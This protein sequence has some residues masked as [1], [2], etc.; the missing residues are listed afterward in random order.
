MCVSHILADR[1]ELVI[2]TLQYVRQ[3]IRRVELVH[4]QTRPAAGNPLTELTP[5][6]ATTTISVSSLYRNHFSQNDPTDRTTTRTLLQARQLIPVHIH[7]IVMNKAK[8]S[9]HISSKTLVGSGTDGQKRHTMRTVSLASHASSRACRYSFH[10]KQLTSHVPV[11]TGAW[12]DWEVVEMEGLIL[13]SM[14]LETKHALLT[15]FLIRV[16]VFPWLFRYGGWDKLTVSQYQPDYCC[17]SRLS[18]VL[19]IINNHLL[20]SCSTHT[21]NQGRV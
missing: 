10:S 18:S 9:N 17:R 6:F 8:M 21:R 20:W 14:C 2:V 4:R 19:V 13:S 7:R 16:L 5:T 12:D 15:K 3:A 11:F 1:W